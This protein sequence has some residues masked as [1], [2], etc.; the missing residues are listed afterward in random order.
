MIS[1]FPDVIVFLSG[2]LSALFDVNA[3]AGMGVIRKHW[4]A[5]GLFLLV[6][7]A[8]GIVFL[9]VL[10]FLEV[11]HPSLTPLKVSILLLVGYP[12]LIHSNLIT[13]P[14]GDT[15]KEIGF[16]ALYDSLMLL[17]FDYVKSL[18]TQQTDRKYHN[19]PT[20]D[21]RKLALALADTAPDKERIEAISQLQDE[22]YKKDW[23]AEFCCK[24]QAD[25]S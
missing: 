15:R 14:S 17:Y 4:A 21:L 9:R 2:F 24:K 7:G 19:L 12:L 22:E 23:Y 5:T 3:K 8:V 16:G 25:H 11:F 13:V 20:D 18:E 1:V 6:M 10:L